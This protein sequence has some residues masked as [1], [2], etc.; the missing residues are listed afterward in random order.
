MEYP[1]FDY[2]MTKE[3][4]YSLLDFSHLKKV[5]RFWIP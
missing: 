4:G 2:F 3:E 5:G 1:V